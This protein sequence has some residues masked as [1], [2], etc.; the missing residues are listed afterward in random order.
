VGYY[1]TASDL[2]QPEDFTCNEGIFADLTM[3]LKLFDFQSVLDAFRP[4]DY[5]SYSGTANDP[6]SNSFTSPVIY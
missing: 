1:L 5:K 4:A 6:W 3:V 2:E